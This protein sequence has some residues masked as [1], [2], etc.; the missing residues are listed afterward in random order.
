[1]YC[2]KGTVGVRKIVNDGLSKHALEHC[3]IGLFGWVNQS[4]RS[5]CVTADKLITRTK[6]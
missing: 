1:M 6:F 4:F 3:I 2:A 5:Q